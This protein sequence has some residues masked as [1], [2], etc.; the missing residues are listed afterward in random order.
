MRSINSIAGLTEA[1]ASSVD[2]QA[3]VTGNIA[4]GV[5]SA[6]R[7]ATT[8]AEALHA[9]ETTLQSTREASQAALDLSERLAVNALNSSAAMDALFEA[10]E[11]N[12]SMKIAA[13]FAMT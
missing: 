4:D 11:K 9:I 10:A 1:V 7:T 6:A 12:E 5:N 2:Q 8:V 3:G 13:A